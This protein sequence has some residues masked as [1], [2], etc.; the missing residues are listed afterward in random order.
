M[1][2]RVRQHG[3][4][5]LLM[6]L[7]MTAAG[8][9]ASSPSSVPVTNAVNG[10]QNSTSAPT[11]ALA[12]TAAPSATEPAQ[13]SGLLPGDMLLV[14]C[15]LGVIGSPDPGRNILAMTRTGTVRTLVKH[16]SVPCAGGGSKPGYAPAY[17][18]GSRRYLVYVQGRGEAV[19]DL[20]N[21]TTHVISD[22]DITTWNNQQA[23]A[24]LNGKAA[25]IAPSGFDSGGD[26]TLFF[27]DAPDYAHRNPSDFYKQTIESLFS[28]G[29]S[30]QKLPDRKVCYTS[31]RW[32]P[33]GMNCLGFYYNHGM[34][35]YGYGNSVVGSDLEYVMNTTSP[36]TLKV[37]C[38]SNIMVW[39][40]ADTIVGEGIN[41]DGKNYYPTVYQGHLSTSG[42]VSVYA[43]TGD[44]DISLFGVVGDAVF[45]SS[46]TVSKDKLEI[47][48]LGPN[49]TTEPTLVATFD[50]S[51]NFTTVFGV[52]SLA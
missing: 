31:F 13:A 29:F 14:E 11:S 43:A 49:P 45:I 25:H 22:S 50:N 38:G 34:L 24:G 44:R 42:C 39:Q 35:D 52:L 1:S 6:P 9:A 5:W 37:S 19:L 16:T 26:G 47:Y 3:F 10:E 21:G 15:P 33:D 2:E 46:E 8:C 40:S 30:P 27:A 48:R 41:D 36:P 4:L 12:D 32:S 18:S 7:L 17:L 23:G 28:T 20:S 51:G